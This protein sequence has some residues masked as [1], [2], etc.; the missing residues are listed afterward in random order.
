MAV[1]G[2]DRDQQPLDAVEATPFARR[3]APHPVSPPPFS[4]Y[5][6]TVGGC[7]PLARTVGRCEIGLPADRLDVSICPRT[8]RVSSM[9]PVY[10]SE[11]A[12]MA[13][14][15]AEREREQ[16]LKFLTDQVGDRCASFVLVR[17][18]CCVAGVD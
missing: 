6:S 12:R 14:D 10:D 7:H 4:G 11:F 8:R 13:R 1:A 9:G 2:D 17:L 18:G 3:Q 5:V 15:E 16:K